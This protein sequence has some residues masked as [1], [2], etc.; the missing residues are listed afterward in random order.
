M[1]GKKSFLLYCDMI[2]VF[3]ELTD[4]QAGRLIK[5][6][7]EYV[8]DKNPE[9]NDQI[10]KVSFAPIKAQ[11]KRDLEDWLKICQRNRGNGNSGGRPKKNQEDATETE[12]LKEEPIKPSGFKSNPENPSK[13]DNDNDNDNDIK[14]HNDIIRGLWGSQKW[15]EV[16]SISTKK[17]IEE[18][19]VLLDDFRLECIAKSEL[20]VDDKDAKTHFVN[21][22]RKRQVKTP[23]GNQ[24]N[25]YEK[26]NLKDNWW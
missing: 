15:L 10:L 11:L 19:R 7:F 8:N 25:Q 6:I 2:H 5:H 21:W 18:I 20:K 14:K 22:V 1:Q 4:E 9:L 13:P 12:S 23:I 26:S 24:D 3:E 17:S 16:T